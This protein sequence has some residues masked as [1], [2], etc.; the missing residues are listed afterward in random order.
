MR[1]LEFLKL[2]NPISLI[3]D[4]KEFTE[5]Y[6]FMGGILTEDKVRKILFK[7]KEIILRRDTINRLYSIVNYPPDIENDEK[8]K[9][10]FLV[11]F[12]RKIDEMLLECQLNDLIKPYYYDRKNENCWLVILSPYS[13][14]IDWFYLIGRLMSLILFTILITIF[15]CKLI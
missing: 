8:G 4:F 2:L 12:L 7:N 5:N 9:F 3:L 10:Q 11:E 14:H 6:P 13:Y 15:I 1:F